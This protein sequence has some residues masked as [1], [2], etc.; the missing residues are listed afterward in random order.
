MT[1][2]DINPEPYIDPFKTH[3]P[4][5]KPAPPENTYELGITMA[6]AISGGAYTAGVL[7]YLIEALDRWQKLKEEQ[8]KNHGADKQLWDIPFHDVMITAMTGASA[9]SICTA[10]AAKTLLYK[11]TPCDKDPGEYNEG[12]NSEEKNNRNLLFDVWV[13]KLTINNL[14][15]SNDIKPK[16][17]LASL[18]DSSNLKTIANDAIKYSG[19]DYQRAYVSPLL[20]L[21]FSTNNLRGITY[22]QPFTGFY[23]TSS[24]Y[25]TDHQDYIRFSL[26]TT[27]GNTKAEFENLGLCPDEIPL[28]DSVNTDAHSWVQFRQAVLGSGAFPV[29]MAAREIE[30][31]KRDDESKADYLDYR[32]SKILLPQ[33]SETLEA[34]YQKLTPTLNNRDDPNDFYHSYLVD[35]GTLDNEPFGICHDLVA[36]LEG[37]NARGDTEANRGIMMIDPFPDITAGSDFDGK[38]GVL[39]IVKAM[40]LNSWKNSARFSSSDTILALNK[41]ISSRFL[42]APVRQYPREFKGKKYHIASTA[43]EAFGGFLHRNYRLHDFMLGRHNCQRFLQE[44]FVLDKDNPIF[45]LNGEKVLDEKWVNDSGKVP[46]IPDLKDDASG[47]RELATK[48]PIWPENTT[49]DWKA[50]EKGLNHRFDKVIKKLSYDLK[51]GWK[52]RILISIIKLSEKKSTIQS[53]LNTISTELSEAELANNAYKG[54]AKKRR[55]KPGTVR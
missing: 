16:E 39:D 50:L 28:H 7:D 2:P 13:N 9:G 6:G 51:A 21:V 35:G 55:R 48:D 1:N 22:Q 12:S 37:S 15:N 10:L 44:H 43:M 25:V 27:P 34:A 26:K 3:R 19:I 36:G 23:Q 14:L 46:I 52:A 40:F 54:T 45:Y 30:R 53:L 29:F 32:Y 24:Y 11:H 49:V 33:E 41:N 38:P 31:L 42:I 8:E 47:Y 4:I 18:L 20:R 17:K 5:K